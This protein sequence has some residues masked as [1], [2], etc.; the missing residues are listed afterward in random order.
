MFVLTQLLTMKYLLN[1][2]KEILT[3]LFCRYEDLLICEVNIDEAEW[4]KHF[5]RRANKSQYWH[6][7]NKPPYFVCTQEVIPF[8]F[9]WCMSTSSTYQ[10]AQA[11]AEENLW[12][13]FQ[14]TYSKNIYH[15]YLKLSLNDA[16]HLGPLVM[17][18]ALLWMAHFL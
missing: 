10:H 12:H 8:V 7:K 2:N 11:N 15:R 13:Y 1:N 18:L 14:E 16:K 3:S 9:I 5:I 17:Q 4:G 6:K